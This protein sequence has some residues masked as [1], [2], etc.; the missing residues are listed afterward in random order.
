MFVGLLLKQDSIRGTETQVLDQGSSHCN[1]KL[2]SPISKCAQEWNRK[3]REGA[4]IFSGKML[5]VTFSVF[6]SVCCFRSHGP[7][8]CLENM[9][10]SLFPFLH[11]NHPH[12][13]LPTCLP[14]SAQLKT[15]LGGSHP[16]R[17]KKS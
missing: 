10:P 1:W 11:P 14:N 13:V 7:R 3:A 9:S 5:V 6:F 8:A 17:I 15:R 2:K 4:I 16:K 12:F